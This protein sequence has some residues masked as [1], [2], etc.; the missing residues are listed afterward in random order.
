MT[1][2]EILKSIGVKESREEIKQNMRSVKMQGMTKKETQA[3]YTGAA[4]TNTDYVPMLPLMFLWIE[5]VWNEES[6]K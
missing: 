4:L 2:D 6:K 3:L 1:L 5:E